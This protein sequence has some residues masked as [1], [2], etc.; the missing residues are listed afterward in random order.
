MV[1]FLQVDESGIKDDVFIRFKFNP[2]KNQM[3]MKFLAVR[4]KVVHITGR[5]DLSDEFQNSLLRSFHGHQFYTAL[6]DFHD[7]IYAEALV[8]GRSDDSEDAFSV[9]AFEPEVGSDFLFNGVQHVVRSIDDGKVLASVNADGSTAAAP[10][11]EFTRTECARLI[12]DTCCND[13]LD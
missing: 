4:R 5:G 6:S 7:G 1:N 12:Y 13:P 11:I 9:S 2:A 3:Q 8:D 10:L